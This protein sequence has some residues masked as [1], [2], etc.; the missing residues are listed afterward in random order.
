[1][2]AILNLLPRTAAI[3]AVLLGLSQTATAAEGGRPGAYGH[4]GR[5]GPGAPEVM[6]PQLWGAGSPQTVIGDDNF[7]PVNNRTYP[8]SA[9]TYIRFRD[10]R[11]VARAC[12]GFLIGPNTV[13]TAARCLHGGKAGGYFPKASFLIFPGAKGTSALDKCRATKIFVAAGWIGT[14][15]EAADYGAI[16]VRCDFYGDA[17]GDT[18]GAF[19]VFVPFSL[20]GLPDQNSGLFAWHNAN[21]R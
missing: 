9:L 19:G 17:V 4:P 8:Y 5:L 11:G 16:K 21:A 3:A 18:V 12:S 20:G 1:V 10:H 13:A 15:A 2:R 7:L 6:V 14:S